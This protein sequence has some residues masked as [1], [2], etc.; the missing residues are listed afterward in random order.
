MQAKIPF[1]NKTNRSIHAGP[2]CIRPGE[3]RMVEPAHLPAQHRPASAAPAKA[4]APAPDDPIA[5]LD[6]NVASVAEALPLLSAED[7]D[8]LEAAEQAG[9]TRK[10][11]LAAITAER[12][13]RAEADGTNEA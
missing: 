12:L 7:L 11:V 1:T 13:R 2:V 8:E 6:A 4:A 10:G 5:L 3:T 9:K